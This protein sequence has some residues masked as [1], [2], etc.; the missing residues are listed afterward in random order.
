MSCLNLNWPC[1]TLGSQEY[2]GLNVQPYLLG[3]AGNLVSITWE[4]PNGITILDQSVE[5]YI[6]WIKLDTKYRGT[7]KIKF[8]LSTATSSGSTQ[9]LSEHVTLVVERT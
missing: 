1:A 4:V 8:T 6:A 3:G 2:Y 5:G 9:T 7:F